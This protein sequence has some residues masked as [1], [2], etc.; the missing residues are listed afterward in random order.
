MG[1]LLQAASSKRATA[2]ADCL[3]TCIQAT[4]GDGHVPKL[5]RTLPQCNRIAA[6]QW[7]RYSAAA[8]PGG[9]Q[10]LLL[11]LRP[12]CSHAWAWSPSG[13]WVHHHQWAAAVERPHLPEYGRR[14]LQG[15]GAGHRQRSVVR[16][17]QCAN[18]EDQQWW[19]EPLRGLQPQ[20]WADQARGCSLCRECG[21]AI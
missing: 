7:Q 5:G 8:L 19:P 20:E 11:R 17:P 12:V 10:C 2:I 14:S 6:S 1:V 3:N 15:G 18:L 13:P 4:T 16:Q 21:R 9:S